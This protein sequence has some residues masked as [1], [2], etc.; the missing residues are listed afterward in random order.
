LSLP[1]AAVVAEGM[2]Q[3]PAA[4]T[5]WPWSEGNVEEQEMQEP[6]VQQ[7]P[8]VQWGIAL[9]QSLERVSSSNERLNAFL[10]RLVTGLQILTTEVRD[11]H[12]ADRKDDRRRI[13]LELISLYEGIRALEF[14]LKAN[15]SSFSFAGEMFS[16]ISKRLSPLVVQARQA[17]ISCGLE[18][19]EAGEEFVPE[20]DKPA[21]VQQVQD[22]Q[23]DR[24]VLRVEAPGYAWADGS[25]VLRL[26][27][28]VVGQFNRQ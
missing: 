22:P 1:A 15:S 24:K 11:K 17:L 2:I 20:L 8:P 25:G 5:R 19:R 14:E 10:Q 9:Q 26:R 23:S 16:S 13:A 27:H 4:L 21:R 6:I 3:A 28:V 7:P 12:T 18:I